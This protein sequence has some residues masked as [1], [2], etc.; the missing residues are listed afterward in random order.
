L[1]TVAKPRLLV[2]TSTYPRWTDDPTTP[3][4]VHELARRLVAR[5]DVHLLAPHFPGASCHE[6]LDGVHVHRYRYAPEQWER[7]AYEGGI[8]TRLRRNPW[9]ALMVPALLISQW[10]A[11]KRLQRD[12]HVVHAH[13]VLP[14]GLLAVLG[15][16]IPVLCTAHG[17]DLFGL[18]SI[19]SGWLKRWTLRHVSRLTVVSRALAEEALRNGIEPER[20]LVAPMGVDLQ[21][22]FIP[23]DPA[24]QDVPTLLF[25]GRLVAKKGVATLIEALPAIRQRHPDAR[26]RVVGDGPERERLEDLAR[27]LEIANAVDFVGAIANRDLPEIFRAAEVVVFPSVIAEDGDREG[28]GLVA[29][30]ALGCACAVVGSDLPAMQEYLRDG[31]TGLVTRAGDANALAGAVSDLLDDPTL[32]QRLGEAGRRYV[33]ERYDWT[34]VA[35]GY[36]DQL[37]GL[38]DEMAANGGST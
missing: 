26:L 24:E 36:A 6:V 27:H 8:L 31:E 34:A 21:G 22:T 5:F 12:A 1:H 15:R 13:W 19:L 35:S 37:E 20:V 28:F 33:V 3:A 4:F 25:V 10:L 9:L 11:T 23:G 7:L 32:R 38:I 29:V 30:E 16:R 17:G 2:L 14:Q 18:Q